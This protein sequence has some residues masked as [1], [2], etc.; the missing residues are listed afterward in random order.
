MGRSTTG[1]I[2]TTGAIGGIRIM[3][4]KRTMI[5][6]IVRRAYP[7]I[8]IHKGENARN[9][10]GLFGIRLVRGLLDGELVYLVIGL[11][12]MSIN[13]FDLCTRCILYILLIKSTG[14]GVFAG[15][16]RDLSYLLSY[17]RLT[18]MIR[19]TK[20]L[21]AIDLDDSADLRTSFGRIF[22]RDKDSAYGIRPV[23]ALRG[24]IP[25]RIKKKDRLGD[26]MFSI[27]SACKTTLE[28]ALFR[29]MSACSIATTGSFY[30]VGTRMTRKVGYYLASDILKGLNG[31]STIRTMI[32]GKGDGIDLSTTRND[33]RLIV[34]RRAMM[35]IK[36]G[37]GRGLTRDG[38]SYRVVLLL[39]PWW[40]FL[41]L[42]E[43]RWFRPAYH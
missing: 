13:I 24:D 5:L 35:T 16:N 25:V 32:Y 6:T 18:S 39:F 7:I 20:G 14:V 9:G 29:V 36:D 15:L 22:T 41:A 8:I 10:Y 34:L 27:M 37:T 17:P 33:L 11:T 30:N 38:C 43:R 4:L 1:E 19:I 26:K 42:H 21:R 31:V 23:N 2:T 28:D 12:T 3:K 40:C